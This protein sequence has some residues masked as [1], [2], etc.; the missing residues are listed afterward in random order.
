MDARK[1]LMI[2]ACMFA[3]F[4]CKAQDLNTAE[5]ADST[6]T[7][8]FKAGD[9]KNVV[10]FGQQAV[11]KGIDFVVLRQQMGY[12]Y[13][14]IGNYSKA[15]VEYDAVLEKDPKNKT[16]SYYAYLCAKYLN[17]DLQASWYA[18]RLDTNQ[19]RDE[20]IGAFAPLNA[21][22]EAGTKD[23]EEAYRSNAT[24]SRLF[25]SNRLSWRLQLDQSYLNFSQSISSPII[26]RERYRDETEILSVT[27]I[28]KQY[29]YYAKLGFVINSK[30]TLIGSYH[31]LNTNFQN[32]TYNS[33]IGLA[34][35][36]YAGTYFDLQADFNWGFMI[37][38]HLLQY[39]ASLLFYPLGNLNLYTITRYS[40]LNQNALGQTIFTQSLGFKAM[41]N[42]W[43]ETG[44]TFGNMDNYI[45]A[46]GLYIYNSIDATKLKLGETVFY[47][48]GKHAQ[49]QLNYAIEKK[50]DDRHD[51]NYNQH[52]I[53]AAL[54]WKF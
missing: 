25:E 35:L 10:R 8:L 19:L 45:D 47:Q 49:L 28:D 26:Y 34:G 12:A 4:E 43:L 40:Y 31:Y 21:G 53:T 24:Y 48:L 52:S 18:S 9:W 36:K 27:N 37:D 50:D 1:Y 3:L 39:N 13:F 23:P 22:I 32:I 33:N 14:I 15:L 54:L 20:K 42:V 41:A 44:L 46:D 51:I 2:I 38:R 30:F 29:E 11:D 16:A 5:Q 17:H 7:R 6:V